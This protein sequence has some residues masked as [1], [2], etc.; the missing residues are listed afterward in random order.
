LEQLLAGEPLGIVG[1]GNI[2]KAV[3]ARCT[4]L[5][6]NYEVYDPWLA[7]EFVDHA[8]SLVEVLGCGVISIHAELTRRSPWPS[9]RLLGEDELAAISPE[10]LLV[11]AGRGEIVNNKALL[12]LRRKGLGPISVLDVWEG[13]PT[14]LPGLLEFAALGTAHISGYSLDGKFLATKMLRDAVFQYFGVENRHTPSGLEAMAALQ[15]P[16][17][18]DGADLLR[19]AVHARYDI[20]EDDRLLRAATIGCSCQAARLA[21]DQLRKT[22]RARREL[23]GSSALITGDTGQEKLLSALGC[24]IVRAS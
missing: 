1:Y 23:W 14:I 13:E 8:A 5:G 17:G 19:W 7:P 21:F 6:I 2:G 10:T 16:P 15:V 11:N 20:R 4:A 9:Y 18:L 22:Y 3:A 12:E 24:G